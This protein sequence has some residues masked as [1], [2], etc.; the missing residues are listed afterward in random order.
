MTTPAHPDRLARL[1]KT[2]KRK[3]I[4]ALL[5][6]HP[7]NRRYLSGY[8]PADHS[9]RESSGA[10]LVPSTG[11]PYLFTDSRFVLQAEEE[12]AGFSVRLYS[13]GL[14]HTLQK[15]LP[16]CGITTLAFEGDYFLHSSFERLSRMAEKIQ[17]QLVSLTGIV[18]RLRIIKTEEEIEKIRAS[19]LLNE[20]VFR[21]VYKKIKPGMTEKKIALALERAMRKMGAESPGF[22]TIVAFGTNAA[23]PHAVPTKRRLI[24]GETV[25]V[26]MGLILDG[27]CSDM[28]RTFVVGKPGKT[29]V[30]RLRIVRRAQKAAIKVI[31]AGVTC[32]EVDRAA[33]RVIRDSGY[34]KNF[35]HALGHGVGLEVH[36]EPRLS[37]GSRRKLQPGM[38]V[39][40]E[41]GIYLP[42]WGGIRLEN[43]V[44]VR[45]NGC[46]PL[47]KDCTFLDL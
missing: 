46:E 10:L 29:F 44:V 16:E 6:T 13:R 12:A 24:K 27:Y 20:Q 19:V 42:D 26:D 21:K 36:E 25:L 7:A 39:T 40:V 45:E 35:G 43:M 30:K 3:R 15:L 33:R 32:R 9:I 18:E 37:S 11:R 1:Q 41:P 38:I 2:L 4:S 34:G 17:V 23:R 22:D 47:N 5:V 28:S 14:A 8:T 31:R